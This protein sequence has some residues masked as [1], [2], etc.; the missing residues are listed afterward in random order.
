[1][2]VVHSIHPLCP[3]LLCPAFLTGKAS[4][5]SPRTFPTLTR[6]LGVTAA[7]FGLAL[8]ATCYRLYLRYQPG[9]WWDDWLALLA[10]VSMALLVI[11][12]YPNAF[13]V[14]NLTNAD[15]TKDRS[16]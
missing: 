13:L 9:I 10:A 6:M 8:L 7:L 16:C 14:L 12:V 15:C 4:P 11:G 5:N 2:I 1:M 3:E